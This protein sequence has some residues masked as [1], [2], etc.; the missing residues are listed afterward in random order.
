MLIVIIPVWI[1]LQNEGLFF[2]SPMSSPS[3]TF[4]TL[5]H[6]D[7]QSIYLFVIFLSFCYLLGDSNGQELL[8]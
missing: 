2:Y 8:P 4:Y 7:I 6:I 3:C 1:W 5:D